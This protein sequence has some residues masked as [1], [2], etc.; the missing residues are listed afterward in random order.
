[1]ATANTVT[2]LE[3]AEKITEGYRVLE[4]VASLRLHWKDSL[5]NCALSKPVTRLSSSPTDL[6]FD[7]TTSPGGF[8][9]FRARDYD[10]TERISRGSYPCA[11]LTA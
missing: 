3:R 6:T 8:F 11:P 10:A 9:V 2:S 7:Q 1:M 5:G 4:V